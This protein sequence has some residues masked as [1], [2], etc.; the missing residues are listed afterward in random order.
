[1]KPTPVLAVLALVATSF[2][3]ARAE[4]QL[5]GNPV[6]MTT[7]NPVLTSMIP[8]GSGG[9]ILAFADS[10][11]GDSDIYVQRIS[12]AGVPLWTIDGVPICVAVNEQE[13]PVLVSDGAGGAIVAWED[14]RT[15]TEDIYVQRITAAGVPQWTANG[16][17]LCTAGNGQ[18]LP[19]I[20]SD[21]AGGA[22][23]TWRDLRTPANGYDI[24]ARRVN[25]AGT[26]LWTANGVALCTLAGH[27]IAPQPVI[28]GGGGV[29]I[30]WYDIRNSS[31][32]DIYA[33]R[34]NSSGTPQWAANGVALCTATGDQYDPVVVSDGA[35]G[36]IAAWYDNR[37]EPAYDIYA[38]RINS[39]GAPLWQVDGIGISTGSGSQETPS[40][41]ADGAGGAIIAWTDSRSGNFDIY[42]Q[43]VTGPGVPMWTSNGVAVCSA[44][45]D[46]SVLSIASD[47]ASGAVVAW[48]DQRFG[49]SDI[50]ARRVNANGL[51]MWTF[52]GSPVCSAA[53]S[54]DTP[55][56]VDDGAG[57][58]IIGWHDGRGWGQVYVQ[59]AEPRYGTWGR[60][61]PTIDS[62]DDNPGDQ[63]GQVIVRWIASEHDRF[64]YPGIS[65]Y[66][67]WRATD[68]AAVQALASSPR[69]VES[70]AE[71][72]RDFAGAALWEEPTANGPV[73]WEWVANQ[74]AFYQDTYSL[75]A[76]TRQDEVPGVPAPHYFK[77]FAHEASYPQTR[78]WESAVVTGSSLDNL[79]PPAPRDLVG[80]P[81]LWDIPLAW[82]IDATPPDFSHYAVYRGSMVVA[83]APQY[84]IG[85]SEQTNFVDDSP[86]AGILRYIVTAIDV[87]GNESVP[88][89]EWS[90]S[91]ATPVGD[92]PAI[93]SLAVLDNVPNPFN[94]TTTFRV[95]LAKTTDVE[96]EVFDV[97]GQ[98]VRS[99]RT[100][101]MAAGWH[102]IDFQARDDVGRAL[103]SGVYFYR[104]KAAGET[105]TRKMV[106]AR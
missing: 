10:R 82:D 8:D 102:R 86:P 20:E 28:D 26:P 29:I 6:T 61:E 99:E 76:P 71:I 93:T 70:P 81:T 35:A 67:V 49:P 48:A 80:A 65:H 5:D 97:A 57:G 7:G 33:Q 54:Q 83:P 75:L 17:A 23:V 66:S 73:F 12:A 24:Y 79:A 38:R 60:P 3:T 58:A 30:A 44:F 90:P 88:S 74:N 56:V 95:G 42:A 92:A 18:Y 16:V 69:I 27:Q 100:A 52:D 1:M 105:I 78:T 72:S 63:G 14:T 77:V 101:T 104:V 31:H 40:I 94:R 89:N 34:L 25:S 41:V 68:F 50:Y 106:I 87:H 85:T 51:P 4:W 22:I 13:G 103:P 45:D 19:S 55:R 39:A 53:N 46:Q 43:R 15:A 2:D 21:G 91:G 37:N 59:R 11:N 96:I 62:A 84:L 32:Y 9:A 36:A 98:R 47:G 64:Y